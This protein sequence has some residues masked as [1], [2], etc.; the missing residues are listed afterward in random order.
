MNPEQL[1]PF[2]PGDLDDLVDPDDLAPWRRELSDPNDYED[3]QEFP[4]PDG[5][6]FDE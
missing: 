5:W 3:R 2:G 1:G 4:D 6:C